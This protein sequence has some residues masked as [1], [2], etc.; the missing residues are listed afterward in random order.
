MTGSPAPLERATLHADA[1]G[2]AARALPARVPLHLHDVAL[3]HLDTLVRVG[4]D[5]VC[6]YAGD[7][8]GIYLRD[9]RDDVRRFVSEYALVSIARLLTALEDDAPAPAGPEPAPEGA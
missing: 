2:D 4:L 5:V 1:L 7:Q 8:A 3:P 9:H 6:R